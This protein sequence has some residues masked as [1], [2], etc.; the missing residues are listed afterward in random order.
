MAL[1]DWIYRFE[2]PAAAVPAVIAV[3][4]PKNERKTAKTATTATAKAGKVAVALATPTGPRTVTVTGNVTPT[5]GRITDAGLYRGEPTPE[6]IDVADR[7]LTHLADLDRPATE[8]EALAA[9][10]CDET[11]ARNI[12]HRIC[13]EG[14]AEY[15]GRGLRYRI[16]PYPP[17]AADLPEACP[18]LGPGPHPAGCRFD[19]RLLRRMMA[20]GALPLRGGRCPL[21]A[22]CGVKVNRDD[23]RET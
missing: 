5:G 22:V 1:R 20:E 3:Q 14:L 11:M 17:P 18:L 9:A 12:L 2:E 23:G 15:Q 16:P 19:H 21:S 6:A 10:G 13:I 7:I 4:E 8:A